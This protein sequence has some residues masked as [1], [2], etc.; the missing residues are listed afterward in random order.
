MSM[1]IHIRHAMRRFRTHTALIDDHRRW[2]FDELDQIVER[3]SGALQS[4]LEP[5]DRVC[6][7]MQNRSEYIFLQLA[8]ERAGLV[9]VPLNTRYTAYEVERSLDDCEAAAIFCDSSTVGK[10][11]N[12]RSR[13]LWICP[14]D[15]D[16]VSGSSWNE[17][18]S[19]TGRPACPSHDFDA[20]CSINYTS[21]SS[22][23]PKGVMMS[24][25]NWRSVY[26]NMLID[27]SIESG[28]KLAHIGPLTHA[29]GT[30]FTPFLLRGAASVIVA[31]G[32]LDIF[33][34]TIEREKITAFTCVPTVLTRILNH[35]DLEDFDLSSLRWIGF[36][37]EGI[38][39]NTLKKALAKWGPILTQN[40]GLTEAMMT[41][42]FMSGDEYL[43]PGTGEE[44]GIREGCIGRP[45]T[46]VDLV[47]RNQDGSEVDIGDVGE[48]TISSEHVMRG[49]WRKPEETAR[50]LRD[51]WLWS[52]DLARQ[53]EEGYIYLVGR[54]KEM[55]ISGGFNIYPAEVESCLSGCPGVQAA[56]VIGVPDESLGELCVA[57]IAVERGVDLTEAMCERH[58]KPI[59]GFRTPR[60]W[61]F[62]NQLPLTGNGKV[63]KASLKA[64]LEPQG[65]ER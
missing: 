33:L 11:D 27:R 24:H 16:A 32:P 55:F 42:S 60:R 52:G 37:G 20:L 49:Y 17:L 30:Y 64:S 58:C 26:Q 19:H 7:F 10:L 31:S 21:G 50:V 29:S 45:Y 18:M 47:I 12:V 51:E 43:I 65:A 56:A 36:G 44:P 22:G 23:E 34:S 8:L 25:R 46:F 53:D 39:H 48:I 15:G 54:S 41:C 14:V 59:I 6:L 5:G 62:V 57:F 35:A 9:R 3:L 1:D 28:A 2:T 40:Y 4:T 38:P 63:D 61:V 13:P